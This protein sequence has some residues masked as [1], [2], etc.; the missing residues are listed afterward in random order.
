MS[1]QM[2]KIFL[3]GKKILEKD[4]NP[5]DTL[6]K[7]RENI[8]NSLVFTDEN[9]KEIDISDESE[10][11]LNDI[12]KNE[13]KMNLNF[14]IQSKSIKK[15]NPISGT[16]LLE[17]KG[18]LKIYQYPNERLNDSEESSSINI[19]LVGETD[20]GKTTL[21][22]SFINVLMD[23]QITDDFRYILSQ[24]TKETDSINIYNIKPHG[25]IP[26][27]KIIDSPGFG[28][29]KGIDEDIKY[30]D[31]LA[32]TLKNSISH[33][34][35]ICLVIKSSTARLT[36]NQR[37]IFS[38]VLDLFG[39]DVQENFFFML[40]FCDGAKPQVV[41]ALESKESGFNEIISQIKG[42]WFYKFNNSAFF[43]DDIENE[44]NQMFWDINKDSFHE[45]LKKLTQTQ[46][47]SLSQTNEVLKIRQSL[48][49]DAKNISNK[50]KRGLELMKL[51]KQDLSINEN[52]NEFI[53]ITK[54]CLNIQ[55]QI[56]NSVNKLKN[57]ALSYKNYAKYEEI[58]ELL[59][60]LEKDERK[61]YW[62][63]RVKQYE[64]MKNQYKI[65]KEICEGNLSDI[66]S[67]EQFKKEI[68]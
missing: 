55:E 11:T 29:S 63:E 35:A 10:L 46:R 16:K 65:L 8:F 37:Y 56:R 61:P 38:M 9:G 15:N 26:A 57:I 62:T 53:N 25:N 45:F 22:N 41:S 64:D 20:S 44:Y 5:N 1:N 66:K 51:I 17:N 39:K 21:L 54:N 18:K 30:R 27:I 19:L 2:V 58:L 68:I 42:N 3:N 24:D 59:I 12:I 60:E 32:N 14:K 23:I 31:K 48:E 50:L 40:T 6:D 34:N 7:I 43:S 52:K 36:V 4:L 67:L 33:I 49:N 47:K 28:S 13:D